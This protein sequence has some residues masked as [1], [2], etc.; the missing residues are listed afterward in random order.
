MGY[1]LN[2]WALKED[3]PSLTARTRQVLA[4]ICMVAHD[5]HGEFWMRPNQFIAEYLP[6]MSYGAYRNHLMVLVRNNFLIKIEQG[7]GRTTHGR[8]KT[9]RYRVNSPVVKT[10]Q[11]AQGVL[12]D[13]SKSAEALPPKPEAKVSQE[14][15]TASEVYDHVDQLL[16]SGVSPEEMLTILKVI[17]ETFSRTRN[18]SESHAD[19]LPSDLN[20]SG[21]LTGSVVPTT[22]LG[23]DLTGSSASEENPSDNLT[24]LDEE[25]RQVKP[26]PVR[27]S[28]RINRNMSGILTEPPIHEEKSND[29]NLHAAAAINQS[30]STEQVPD[31]FEVLVSALEQAGHAGI[32][33]AQFEH[34]RQL[35]PLYA[36]ATGGVLP[37]R[38]TA[39]YIVGRLMA[40]KG[41]RNVVGYTLSITEDVL[42]TGEGYVEPAPAPS[43]Y[44]P[45]VETRPESTPDWELLHLA[46]LEQIAPAQEIW[47]LAREELRCDVSRPAF[48]TWLAE[49]IGWAYADGRF[50]IGTPSGF[51]SEMLANRLHPLIERALRD[52][53]GAEVAF[54]FAVVP[55]DG[56]ACELCSSQDLQ[57]AAS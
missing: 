16:N 37:D 43:A 51:V 50:V 31:F 26:Y 47:T 44:Q 8:G 2:K 29:V 54:A 22:E 9:T 48:E 53:T 25:T 46:H 56:I 18:L 45:S 13:I 17:S 28:D 42:R 32:R 15:D 20:Q 49:T 7:G 38:D 30:D 52:I 21:N 6:G 11:P 34:L 14:T 23:Q 57:S 12:P 41:V 3:H 5:E 10:A 36:E 1:D 35:M 39:H 24:G 33:A 55:P 19:E 40:S 27:N 4:A